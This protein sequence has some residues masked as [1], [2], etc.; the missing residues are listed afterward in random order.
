MIIANAKLLISPLTEKGKPVRQLL[1]GNT[2]GAIQCNSKENKSLQSFLYG[3]RNDFVS[4]D[5]N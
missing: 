4:Q 5:N 2:C 1:S 3:S